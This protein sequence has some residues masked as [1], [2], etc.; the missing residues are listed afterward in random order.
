M[1]SRN[2]C[3]TF[4]I[5]DANVKGSQKTARACDACYDTVFPIIEA[6][7]E[8]QEAT[9]T[10]SHLTLSG[11]RSMPSLMLEHNVHAS[12]SILMAVD[13]EDSRRPISRDAESL[14]SADL[15]DLGL[16][17]AMRIKPS[18]RPRSYIQ[19]LEDFNSHGK[20]TSMDSPTAS[21]F[22]GRT[23]DQ[24]F[25]LDER[26]EDEA[27][28]TSASPKHRFVADFVDSPKQQRMFGSGPSITIARAP[29][30]ASASTPSVSLPATP[31]GGRKEDTTRRRMR[32]SLPAVAIHTTPVT[33]RSG[34]VGE[35]KSKRWSLVLGSWKSGLHSSD[36][37]AE[38]ARS[39][40]AV[41]KLS[42]LLGRHG[43]TSSPSL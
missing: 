14:L 37:F 22:S 42:E 32:F 4:V 2:V 18:S 21:R 31:R 6:Q 27:E 23:D 16:S 7:S 28:S 26:D 40:S 39:G 24:S 19:I 8:P 25:V 29:T 35:G 20:G 36:S 11:L 34:V 13:L 38:G 3:Q 17:P 1:Y 10:I 30:S 41:G 9:A 5:R 12:P 43:K 15:R 33:T